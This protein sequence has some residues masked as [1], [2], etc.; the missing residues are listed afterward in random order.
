[1]IGSP[2]FR[3]LAGGTD[4]KFLERANDRILDRTPEQA[5]LDYWLDILEDTGDD[6]IG[7]EFFESQENRNRR[8]SNQ[9]QQLLC[10]R[11]RQVT[12]QR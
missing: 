11:Q 5:G 4:Q 12:A 3:A 10:R 6:K 8:V 7:S 2:E 1:M 9:Y